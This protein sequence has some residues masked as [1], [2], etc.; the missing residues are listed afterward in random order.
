MTLGE[1]LVRMRMDVGPLRVGASQAASALKDLGSTTDA[2]SKKAA[3]GLLSLSA[4]GMSMSMKLHPAFLAVGAAA[5]AMAAGITVAGGLVASGLK[6]GIEQAI[7]FEAAF[8]RVRKVVDPTVTSIGGLSKGLIDLSTKIPVAATELAAIAAAGGQMG[9]EGSE[10]ILKFTE[11]VAR[12]AETADMSSESVALALGRIG[13]VTDPGNWQSNIDRMGSSLVYVA[14]KSNASASEILNM[15]RRMTGAAVAAGMTAP[16]IFGVSSALASVGMRAEAGGGSMSSFLTKLSNAVDE[17]G[18]KLALFAKTAGMTSEQFANL[19]RADASAALTAFVEGLGRAGEAGKNMSG[20]LADLGVKEIRQSQSLLAL[21]Q[22]G[23]ILR[24]SLQQANDGYRENTALVEKSDIVFSTVKA[25]LDQL[26]KTFSEIGIKIG[27]AFLPGIALVLDELMVLGKTMSDSLSSAFDA[28]DMKGMTEIFGIFADAISAV[29]AALPDLVSLVKS[30][31]VAFLGVDLTNIKAMA[32]GL[33]E[34]LEL[35]ALVNPQIAAAMEKGKQARLDRSATNFFE[36]ASGKGLQER[37]TGQAYTGPLLQAP[38]IMGGTP[39]GNVP[40]PGP[41]GSGE[42]ERPDAFAK[43]LGEANLEL[44]KLRGESAG[45]W[46]EIQAGIQAAV[47][48][49]IEHAKTLKISSAELAILTQKYREAGAMKMATA[50]KDFVRQ[51]LGYAPG[52]ATRDAAAMGQALPGAGDLGITQMVEIGKKLDELRSKAAA[53][54]DSFKLDDA[55]LQASLD[56]YTEFVKGNEQAIEA[57]KRLQDQLRELGPTARD[58]AIEFEKINAALGDNLGEASTSKLA[59]AFR[60]LEGT[61]DKAAESGNDALYADTTGKLTEIYTE[62][63]SRGPSALREIDGGLVAVHNETVNWKNSMTEVN[64]LMQALGIKAGSL[65]GI[66]MA[67][68]AGIGGMIDKMNASVKSGG[69][70]GFG[71]FLNGIT[72]KGVAGDGKNVLQGIF[73][74]I[75]FAGQ[76]ISIGTSLFKGLKGLFS[77]PSWKKVGKEAGAVLGIEM[78]EE[79]AK[80]VEATAKKLG[81]TV[82]NAALLSLP[83]AISSSGKDARGFGGQALDLLAGIKSGAIPA[84]EGMKALG[85]SFD[86]IKDAA[87]DAGDVGSNAMVALIKSAREAGKMTEEMKAFV[88]EQVDIAIGGTNKAFG[89]TQDKDGNSI[90]QGI[91][92]TTQQSAAAQATIF[93]TVF[94]A[95][96]KEKGLIGAADALGGTFKDLKERLTEGGFDV[97]AIFDPIERLMN[98]SQDPKFRGAAEGANGLNEALKGLANSGY[99]TRDAFSAFGTQAQAAF[100]QAFAATGDQKLALEAIAPLLGSLRNSAANYGVELDEQT[101]KL[102]EDAE[103]AGIVFPEEPLQRIADLLESIATALGATIPAAAQRAGQA[104]NN[105]PTPGAAGYGAQAGGGAEADAPGYGYTGT[106]GV[107]PDVTAAEG[108]GPVLLRKDTVIQAHEGEV[109]TIVPKGM[110]A[111]KDSSRSTG[112]SVANP[113]RVGDIGGQRVDNPFSGASSS[114]QDQ[115][116]RLAGAMQKLTELAGQPRV[117]VP[118][119]FHTHIDENPMRSRQAQEEMRRFTLEEV[120]LAFQNRK[121]TLINTVKDALGM[122]A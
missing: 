89:N 38:G 82:K 20:I 50:Q 73:G 102:I 42:R 46:P 12:L 120:E 121:G 49:E 101:K 56:Y 91:D 87:M 100:D 2:Q 54:G 108:F 109:A 68:S 112:V 43:A 21:A 94:W 48:K 81:I 116:D 24:R 8:A 72:G 93:S 85:E 1:L 59:A 26:G 10:N 41:T 97:S 34:I 69:M 47:D 114:Q 61:R 96:V 103:G 122:A 115:I 18:A 23:D 63:E 104:I 71:G 83:E 62:L 44:Q 9:L 39:A 77:E 66:L 119:E 52:D 51:Q 117:T 33:K 53:N 17:G 78:S 64:A 55:E 36:S 84:A 67:A 4:A 5:A 25:K 107:P 30:M 90:F 79:M 106:Y 16:Q 113:L 14:D 65:P 27:S 74:S 32:Q 76:A 15:S 58:I 86:A 35:A 45:A 37:L 6:T 70:G 80:K 95:A 11:T 110:A 105:L 88:G 22:G 99:M 60:A 92:A 13:E 19:F 3:G 118:T 40:R 98:F 111:F 75:G 31:S 29:N 28:S 57:S 7:A